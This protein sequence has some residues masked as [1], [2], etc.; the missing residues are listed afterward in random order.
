M[1][2]FNTQ[3]SKPTWLSAAF[4]EI[5]RSQ[6]LNSDLCD[7]LRAFG[8]DDAD[9]PGPTSLDPDDLDDSADFVDPITHL[10]ERI[11][12]E[13]L[14]E[15]DCDQASMFGRR[16]VSVSTL[17]KEHIYDK[18]V[19][20][21][22]LLRL[23][24][25]R[26]TMQILSTT[27]P[28]LSKRKALRI[29]ALVDFIWSLS[30]VLELK[31]SPGNNKHP[32]LTQLAS[33]LGQQSASHEFAPGFYHSTIEGT[34][35]DFGPVHIN[36][37]RIN[38]IT[39]GCHMKCIDARNKSTDLPTLAKEMG[40]VAAISG[41]FFLYSEPDIEIPSRRSD[42][43]GL[44]VSDGEIVGPPVFQ[45]STILQKKIG[46]DG[47]RPISLN[48]IGMSG[49]TCLC[50]WAHENSDLESNC[51]ELK[52]GSSL[53]YHEDEGIAHATC[54][55]RADSEEAILQPGQ[56]AFAI[57]GNK[58]IQRK[59]S[60]GCPV[61]MPVPLAGFVLIF[62]E[63]SLTSM[64]CTGRGTKIMY[65]HDVDIKV[66]YDFP[67]SLNSIQNAMA[68]GPMFFSDDEDCKSMDLAC[69]DFKRSAPPV[70]FSQ[71]ETHDHN[72]LP[73][74]GVGI[75][76]C[77]DTGDEQ[78]VCAAIDGRNL[79]R[80]LGLTLQGTSDLLRSLGCHKAM[81]LDGGSSKR[82]VVWDPKHLEHKVVCLSTTEIKANNGGNGNDESR[83]SSA[84][85]S[86]PVHS[87]IL[88]C[89]DSFTPPVN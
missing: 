68:G 73:R 8:R 37:L 18:S 17:L 32:T 11:S 56:C 77:P 21:K 19:T 81:N 15:I 75:A 84:E 25:H 45:R 49:I 61:K 66:S 35:S 76:K 57:V 53:G 41:G 60:P 40:A 62:P 46:D 65:D 87:A 7:I 9:A 89:S 33:E 23:A 4:D 14:D 43:V 70:T 26:R 55:H 27:D 72:L 31:N 69:E 52:I 74:M 58:V 80:A 10:E 78:L 71:D 44:L 42:P 47:I 34:T 12:T 24:L 82:M 54:V 13:L 86:R 48:K 64:P 36:I 50:S 6:H 2:A 79:D 28:V 85:P 20:S 5:K 16:F 1:S 30:L 38:L 59:I 83:K 3:E 22:Q 39:S 29:R 88:F 63:E 67:S 51:I